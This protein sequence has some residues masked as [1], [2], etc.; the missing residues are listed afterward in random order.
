MAQTYSQCFRNQRLT[1]SAGVKTA[2]QPPAD[3]FRVCTVQNATSGDL[4]VHTGYEDTTEYVIISSGF[5]RPFRAYRRS[6]VLEPV[7]WV[8]SAAGGGV[9]ILWQ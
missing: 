8:K 1:L 4:E 3:G 7:L 2:I 9:I 5:E 6:L